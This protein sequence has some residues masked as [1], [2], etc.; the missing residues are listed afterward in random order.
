MAL[1]IVMV[2]L[3]P[4]SAQG[5]SASASASRQSFTV[6]STITVWTGLCPDDRFLATGGLMTA[7]GVVNDT[8]SDFDFNYGPAGTLPGTLTGYVETYGEHSW[9]SVDFVAHIACDGG[10]RDAITSV[11]W[12]GRMAD[13][14]TGKQYKIS[15]FGRGNSI[16]ADGN[17]GEFVLT[18]TGTA[19][20]TTFTPEQ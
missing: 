8:G 15:G 4:L 12:T 14:D 10:L 11:V 13:F 18:F 19:K 2:A 7:T 17:T 5:A 3:V 9:I 16:S 6:T 20:P 1:A